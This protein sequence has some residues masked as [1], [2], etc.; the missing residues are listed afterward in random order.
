MWSTFD[1]CT[2]K[3]GWR[4]RSLRHH[5]LSKAAWRAA[6]PMAVPQPA[7]SYI[8]YTRSLDRACFLLPQPHCLLPTAG[9]LPP[10]SIHPPPLPVLPD[11]PNQHTYLPQIRRSPEPNR[12]T[13]VEQFY[14]ASH[15]TLTTPAVCLAPLLNDADSIKIY[16]LNNEI[17]TQNK[18]LF[19]NLS[20]WTVFALI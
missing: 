16:G 5:R 17:N 12:P 8:R 6:P 1:L 2:M 15:R 13:H 7:G 3:S 9:C 19:Y 18:Q 10:D 4:V 20:N 11:Q 14:R